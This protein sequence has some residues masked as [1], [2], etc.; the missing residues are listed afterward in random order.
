MNL[1]FNP[2]LQLLSIFNKGDHQPRLNK[3]LNS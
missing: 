1:V 2:I 3:S